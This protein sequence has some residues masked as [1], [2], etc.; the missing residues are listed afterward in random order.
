[1]LRCDK[2]LRSPEHPTMK[3][4]ELVGRLIKNSSRSGESV[5]DPFGGS[6]TTLVAAEE[7]K[8]RAFLMEL[9]PRFCT[10]IIRRWESL[11][12]GAA[13][14]RPGICARKCSCVAIF[15]EIFGKQVADEL[16]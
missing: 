14:L 16:A 11:T 4:V 15:V 6:G 2:P 12:G 1:V 5:L 10:V 8:R 7:L 13:T 3:P 9:D